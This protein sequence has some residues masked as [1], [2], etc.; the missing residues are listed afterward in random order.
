MFR[1]GVTLDNKNIILE[2]SLDLFSKKGYDNTGVQEICELSGF[3]K[4]TLYYYFGSKKG[5][6]DELLNYYFALFDSELEKACIYN[7]DLILTLEKITSAYFEF[8]KQYPLFYKTHIALTYGPSESE[9]VKSIVKKI[10]TQYSV[11]ETVFSSAV[12]QHGNMR[13]R[14]KIYSATFIGT[15]NTYISLYFHGSFNLD[16]QDAFRL[17]HQFMH[18]ILS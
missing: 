14:E 7:G 6:L 3:T 12:V 11:I 10:T 2:K 9:A 16:S 17:V 5:L 4:P 13:G 1:K 8:A 15:I 18:G